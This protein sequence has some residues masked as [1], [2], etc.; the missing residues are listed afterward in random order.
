MSQAL[1]N[2]RHL[3]KAGSALFC[4]TRILHENLA[5]IDMPGGCHLSVRDQEGLLKAAEILAGQIYTAL[6]GQ[7]LEQEERDKQEAA[8]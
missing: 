6:E 7:E 1:E 3:H 2:A 8:Q 4:I 5:Y